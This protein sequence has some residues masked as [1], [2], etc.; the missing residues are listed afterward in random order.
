MGEGSGGFEMKPINPSKIDKDNHA[1]DIY[2]WLL[3]VYG[4]VQSRRTSNAPDASAKSRHHIM[5]DSA[6]PVL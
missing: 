2:M 5:L 4:I 1:V 3:Q 6:F